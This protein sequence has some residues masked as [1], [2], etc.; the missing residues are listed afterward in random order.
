[1]NSKERLT[2]TSLAAAVSLTY[3]AALGCTPKEIKEPRS[4]SLITPSSPTE[5]D[6]LKRSDLEEIISSSINPPYTGNYKSIRPAAINNGVQWKFSLEHNEFGQEEK[7]ITDVAVNVVYEPGGRYSQFTV[8]VNGLDEVA[9]GDLKKHFKP[10]KDDPSKSSEKSI[11][12]STESTPGKTVESSLEKTVERSEEEVTRIAELLRAA[13]KFF[14]LPFNMTVTPGEKSS[15]IDLLTVKGKGKNSLGW[16]I[17]VA[18]NSLG[19]AEY[20]VRKTS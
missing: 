2:I 13:N 12:K 19:A 10:Q 5:G 1:M 3:L 17:E 7:D 6:R 20:S 8:Y 16:D 9:K 15:N 4:V 18:I 14:T 11:Q